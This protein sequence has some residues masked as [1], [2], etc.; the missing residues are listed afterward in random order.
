M[1]AP[2]P[3]ELSLFK[4]FLVTGWLNWEQCMIYV[5]RTCLCLYSIPC[6]SVCTVY[7]VLSH[8]LLIC[9]CI[10]IFTEMDII[11]YV[12]Y[13]HL[14][15]STCIWRVVIWTLLLNTVLLYT[16]TLITV[17]LHYKVMFVIQA[18]GERSKAFFFQLCHTSLLKK[19]WVFS[20]ESL[21]VYL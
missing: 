1:Q 16:C 14:K 2:V 13:E 3:V 15:K 18:A 10:S 4:V 8:K 9:T 20:C 19:K 6:L 12:N 17:C 11:V 21:Y 5:Q 7:H